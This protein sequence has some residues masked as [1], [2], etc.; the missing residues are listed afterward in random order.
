MTVKTPARGSAHSTL[1]DQHIREGD[2]WTAPSS[3]GIGLSV[4]VTLSA[5]CV[6]L[7]GQVSQTIAYEHDGGHDE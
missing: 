3:R 6:P 2:A 4:T 5:G 7:G 1:R